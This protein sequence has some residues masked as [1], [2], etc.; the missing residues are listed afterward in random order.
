MVGPESTETGVRGRA[1]GVRPDRRHETR[2]SDM[3][4]GCPVKARPERGR[5][6]REGP[7]QAEAASAW[8]RLCA[9]RA[10]AELGARRE[11]SVH[12]TARDR[13]RHRPTTTIDF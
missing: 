8:G 12:V 6:E 13:G 3:A 5:P 11:R 10:E 7:R 4:G 9:R 1:A 2:P